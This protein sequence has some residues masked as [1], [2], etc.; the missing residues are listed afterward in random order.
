MKRMTCVCTT[1]RRFQL[2]AFSF[3]LSAF[4]FQ[5]SAF[6]FQLSAFSFQL[7]AFSFQLSAF[8]P[9]PLRGYGG[10]A[11]FSLSPT[12]PPSRPSMGAE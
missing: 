10:Q 12:P 11:A 7:S 1:K 9:S 4:S 2:S 5:L 8:P 3:Q 6:S